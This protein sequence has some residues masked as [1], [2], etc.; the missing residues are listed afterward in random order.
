MAFLFFCLH[1][2]TYATS[3]VAGVGKD[4]AVATFQCR[5]FSIELL[6]ACLNRKMHKL[7]SNIYLFLIPRWQLWR[8]HR[9]LVPRLRRKSWTNGRRLQSGAAWIFDNK[10]LVQNAD[11]TRWF[12]ICP[13]WTGCALTV[14]EKRFKRDRI[15]T[16][17]RCRGVFRDL[18]VH[19]AI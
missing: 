15:G 16:I 14:V 13:I 18:E 2:F 5:R 3:R 6:G 17:D 7:T 4:Y 12:Y 19:K 11:I 8:Y 1:S 9:L 10:T